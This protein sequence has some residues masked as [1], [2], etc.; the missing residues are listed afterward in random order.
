MLVQSISVTDLQMNPRQ[1]RFIEEYSLSGN[2]TQAATAA[3]YSN[4]SAHVTGSRMLRNAKVWRAI[5]TKQRK[6][7]EKAEITREWLIKQQRKVY[8]DAI[9]G[10]QLGPANKALGQLWE[11]CGYKLDKLDITHRDDPIKALMEAV[12]GKTRGLPSRTKH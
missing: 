7:A 8:E 6:A 4:S 9:S 3:G 1:Q 11:F 5:S 10:K 2:A 12:D